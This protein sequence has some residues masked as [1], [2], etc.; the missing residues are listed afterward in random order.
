ML[1]LDHPHF[2]QHLR[3]G[4]YRDMYPEDPYAAE[5]GENA[6]VWRVYLDE[7]GQFDDDMI[8]G[9]R[10]TLDVHLVFVS[11]SYDPSADTR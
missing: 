9:F 10:D 11:P 8:K 2:A 1:W 4:D 6:R 7:S 3:V 5:I